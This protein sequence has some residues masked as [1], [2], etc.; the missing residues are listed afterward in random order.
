MSS[1]DRNRQAYYLPR[2][3]NI[4]SS[5]HR[6]HPGAW[7]VV[8]LVLALLAGL[9]AWFNTYEYG[10]ETSVVFTVKQLDDQAG[11]NGSHKYL[12]FT[13]EPGTHTPAEVFKD[14]DAI[15]H[16][17]WNSSNLYSYLAAGSTYRCT[18]YGFR[19]GFRSSY[20]DALVCSQI[21]MAQAQQYRGEWVK[22]VSS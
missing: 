15:F 2:P 11:S 16:G 5:Q 4:R 7:A 13:D 1:N 6:F 9:T 3:R 19:S 8:I 21:T 12:I 17:K 22:P 10:T 14:T 20:R 18:V